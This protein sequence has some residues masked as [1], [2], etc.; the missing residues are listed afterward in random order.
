MLR[1]V[2]SRKFRCRHS[3]WW[4]GSISAHG[5]QLC[6]NRWLRAS[7]PLS[8]FFQLHKHSQGFLAHIS[9]REKDI[10]ASFSLIHSV[11]YTFISQQINLCWTPENTFHA[12]QS[13]ALATADETPA[14]VWQLICTAFLVFKLRMNDSQPLKPCIN[15]NPPPFLTRKKKL[16]LC[17]W[18]NIQLSVTTVKSTYHHHVL[19][20]KIHLYQNF[21]T[22]VGTFKLIWWVFQK[23]ERLTISLS[24][25]K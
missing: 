11:T 18:L 5:H 14:R 13:L 7:D 10:Q 9:S 1:L 6:H 23:T 17:L 4:R 25:S 12:P 24:F 22:Y 19:K 16:C 2:L 8:I 3:A 21:V 20:K 15:H